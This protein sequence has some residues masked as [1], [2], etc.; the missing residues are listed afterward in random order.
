MGVIVLV[1]CRVVSS[2]GGLVG[3][4]YYG[5]VSECYSAGRVS[6]GEYVGGLVGWNRWHS[7]LSV[8]VRVV[9]RVVVVSVVLWGGIRMAQ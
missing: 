7:D 9:C 5:T 4:N 1:V 2:V 6:G 8:I 3:W